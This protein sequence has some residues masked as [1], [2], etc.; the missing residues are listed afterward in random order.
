MTPAIDLNDV[1]QSLLADLHKESL[2]HPQFGVPLVTSNTSNTPLHTIQDLDKRIEFAEQSLEQVYFCLLS[3]V[4]MAKRRRNTFLPISKLPTEILGA[5]LEMTCDLKDGQECSGE[6][7]PNHM[8]HLRTLAAVSSQFFS[9]VMGMATLWAV[10]D[11]R[12]SPSQVKMCLKRSRGALL[13]VEYNTRGEYTGEYTSKRTIVPRWWDDSLISKHVARWRDVKLEVNSVEELGILSKLSAPQLQR[14]AIDTHWFPRGE[15]IHLFGG[16]A[17]KLRTMDLSGIPV[18]WEWDPSMIA[19]LR[20][21]VLRHCL[22]SEAT[23]GAFLSAIKSSSILQKLIIHDVR[24]GGMVDLTP[25]S[26]SPSRLYSLKEM[27]IT[28]VP[29]DVSRY[30]F[31]AIRAPRVQ[32]ATVQFSVQGGIEAWGQ[33]VLHCLDNSILHHVE[34]AL[35]IELQFG[36]GTGRISLCTDFGPPVLLN[37]EGL[38]LHPD[39]IKW[40]LENIVSHRKQPTL[41]VRLSSFNSPDPRNTQKILP[42]FLRLRDVTRLELE[43]DGYQPLLEFSL[44]RRPVPGVDEEQWLWPRLNSVTVSGDGWESA[45]Q[46]VL[47]LVQGRLEGRSVIGDIEDASADEHERPGRPARIQ[48]VNMPKIA[49]FS[50]STMD[51]LNHLVPNFQLPRE[52]FYPFDEP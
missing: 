45:A 17:P 9:V 12:C 14:I 28:E 37:V 26:E 11:W 33:H 35:H 38:H 46:D 34:Q 3:H 30:F 27:E 16:K 47:E 51:Q 49:C 20:S 39:G 19:N 31:R 2:R 1:H 25:V 52:P 50:K 43:S 6:Q 36:D 40:L 22:I 10:A 48:T 7:S 8:E 23:A 4:A 29:F 18:H 5:I 15:P 44:L 13:A 32:S 42:H 41:S 21:L 24:F